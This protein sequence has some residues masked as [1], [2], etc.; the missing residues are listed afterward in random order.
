MENDVITSDNKENE[1]YTVFTANE[2][3]NVVGENYKSV[4]KCLSILASQEKIRV[5]EKAVNNRVLKGYC[6]GVQ[7]LQ[8]V[9]KYFLKQKHSSKTDNN[10]IKQMLTNAVIEGNRD[11]FTNEEGLNENVKIYEVMK[12][13]AELHKEIDQLKQDIRQKENENIR[14]DADLCKARSEMKL[15]E[16][17]SSSMESAWA[18]EKQNVLNEK[19]KVAQLEKEIKQKD[20][21][22]ISLG[23]VIL[24]IV[25]VAITVAILKAVIS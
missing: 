25:T 15:I 13:N 5:T 11:S 17:K 9:K 24:V 6:L 2:V 18:E 19:E 22:L 10:K 3:A 1:Q 21:V 23:A 12:E 20:K 7:D 4:A 8:E 16:D 14:L